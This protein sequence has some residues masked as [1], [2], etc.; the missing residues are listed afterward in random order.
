MASRKRDRGRIG[1]GR[2][3]EDA[4][5]GSAGDEPREKTLG[6]LLV[7]GEQRPDLESFPAGPK[8]A[9]AFQPALIHDAEGD[10]PRLA[11]PCLDVI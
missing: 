1:F 8:N 2:V 5:A 7:V 9:I 10:S 3:E 4:G 6:G 11:N